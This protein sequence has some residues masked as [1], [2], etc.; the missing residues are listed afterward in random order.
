MF[1]SLISPSLCFPIFAPG[2]VFFPVG[3]HDA[4]VQTLSLQPCPQ[5]Q[6]SEGKAGVLGAPLGLSSISGLPMGPKWPERRLAGGVAYIWEKGR[7][8]YARKPLSPG[9]KLYKPHQPCP[10]PPGSSRTGTSRVP[11]RDRRLYCFRSARPAAKQWAFPGASGD[12]GAA[13]CCLDSVF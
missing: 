8:P 2:K 1:A 12:A 6:P 4:F 13:G 9:Q 3:T 10:R 11:R 7:G 5:R